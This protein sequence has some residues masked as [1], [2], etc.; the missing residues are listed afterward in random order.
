M[1]TKKKKDIN[2]CSLGTYTCHSQATCSNTIG[3]Y[4]CDCNPGYTGDGKVCD[5][6]F[7]FLPTFGINFKSNTIFFIKKKN[8]R[9]WWMLRIK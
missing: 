7:F 1:S 3:S 8:N 4:D 2:E 6:H 9:Y 5:G